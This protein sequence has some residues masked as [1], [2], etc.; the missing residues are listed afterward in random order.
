MMRGQIYDLV[1]SRD[2][3]QILS[4]SLSGDF[5]EEYDKL[6]GQELDIEIKRHREKRSQN[7]NAY[8]WVL[9]EKI[10]D[11]L[12]DDDTKNTKETVYRE[13]IRH[14]GVYRD[15]CDLRPRDAKTLRTAWEMLGTGWL[16]E[17]VDYSPD[18]E[19]VTVRCYYGSSQYN[20][21]QMSRLIDNLVQDAKA[22]GIETLTPNEIQNMLSL[23]E[24]AER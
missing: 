24:Q 19:R 13:A 20:T 10:A 17:Q 11:R 2:G 23:W 15:F 9:C 1:R 22:L 14:I 4:V 18:G 5:T 8:L 6:K 21:K 3:K 7:A 12:A 16:T